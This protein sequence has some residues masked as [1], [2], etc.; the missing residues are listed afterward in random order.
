MKIDCIA[1]THGLIPLEYLSWTDADMVIIAGDFTRNTK[2]GSC[3][4][5]VKE[6]SKLPHR[7]KVVI[8]GNHDGIF[9]VFKPDWGKLGITY[10]ENNTKTFI[11]EDEVITIAGSPYTPKFL[12][13]YFMKTEEELAKIWEKFVCKGIDVLITHCP[14]YGILDK[15]YSG[16]HCGCRS[17]EEALP[18]IDP[19]VHIFGHI[20]ESHGHINA[21]GRDFYNVSILDDKC[22]K[23]WDVTTIEV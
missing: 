9:D 5:R 1:D 15:N 4:E 13:W 11:D 16:D 6:I 23:R 18:G 12:N 7:H 8:A 19:K 14:P 20:H 17:L 10:L 2:W 22:I 3:Y 21:R